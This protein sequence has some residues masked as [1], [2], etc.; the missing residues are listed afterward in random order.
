MTV[1]IQFRH[2][3]DGDFISYNFGQ[4]VL[5]EG[6]K[7]TL[8]AGPDRHQCNCQHYL[9]IPNADDKVFLLSN[10]EQFMALLY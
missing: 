6:V 8:L 7:V 1:Y 3:N 2:L 5:D 4:Y 10:Q 9:D